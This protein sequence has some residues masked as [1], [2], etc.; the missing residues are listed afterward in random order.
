MNSIIILEPLNGAHSLNLGDYYYD[1]ATNTIFVGIGD[2]SFGSHVPAGAITIT[3][4][5]TYD[6]TQYAQAIVSVSGERVRPNGIPV[7][8]R[9]LIAHITAQAEVEIIT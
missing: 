9:N 6:V 8:I 5:G 4:N 7:L 2:L 3:A 1:E